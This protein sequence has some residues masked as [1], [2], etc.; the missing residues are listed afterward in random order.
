[1]AP[2]K[3]TNLTNSALLGFI[4]TLGKIANSPD[5]KQMR[6]EGAIAPL[7]SLMISGKD[8]VPGRAAAVLRDLAQH[9]A[10]RTAILEAD[11]ITQLVKMLGVQSKATVTEAADALR[12]L[13]AGNIAVCTA[14]RA[15]H[16][17][18]ALVEL[19]REGHESPPSMLAA[20]ALSN[21][22][23]ADP[24]CRNE[25]GDKGGVCV[26]CPAP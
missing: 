5:A 4:E 12:S 8:E 24:G 20:N 26:F 14:I 9:S 19:I 18:E 6:D 1:M 2:A 11:G 16:G 13:C 3:G 23:Q 10:N 22:S 21:M 25:I 15:K 17:I 7:V